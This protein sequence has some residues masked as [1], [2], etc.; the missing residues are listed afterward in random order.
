[1]IVQTILSIFVFA[2]PVDTA[3]NSVEKLGSI[4]SVM[5]SLDSD[6]QATS[7]L[8]ISQKEKRAIL[9]FKKLAAFC[10]S[11]KF[12]QERLQQQGFEENL[13]IFDSCRRKLR[14]LSNEIN[15][16]LLDLAYLRS[17]ESK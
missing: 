9:A 14:F 15:P 1:M 2:T 5:R 10:T 11:L 17:Q 4:K 7:S 12:M 13:T 6:Y 3:T 8:L 16:L